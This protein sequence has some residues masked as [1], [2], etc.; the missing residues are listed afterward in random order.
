VDFGGRSVVFS[1]DTRVSENLMRHAQGVDLL[2]HEVVLPESMQRDGRSPERVRSVIAHHTTAEQAGTVFARTHPRL[3][4]FSHIGQP[5]ASPEELLASTRRTYAGAVEV[6]EDLMV[7]D[8]GST[9]SV[10]RSQR[11]DPQP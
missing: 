9:I 1:G 10:H 2:V 11:H 7:I 5:D 3:A 6:G 4:V 8:V